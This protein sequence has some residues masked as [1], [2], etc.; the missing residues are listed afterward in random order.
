MTGIYLKN[1]RNGVI[2]NCTFHNCGTAIDANNSSNISINGLSVI[3]CDKGVKLNNCKDSKVENIFLSHLPTEH[4]KQKQ[5]FKLKNLT[6]LI[7]YYIR[8]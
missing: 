6:F 2:E 8:N 1:C 4:S 3:D 5:N 7:K